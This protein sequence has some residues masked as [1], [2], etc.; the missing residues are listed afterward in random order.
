[1]FDIQKQMD[2]VL[3]DQI[4]QKTGWDQSSGAFVVN[5]FSDLQN[6]LEYFQW[7]H[8]AHTHT[9]NQ[10]TQYI[11]SYFLPQMSCSGDLFLSSVHFSTFQYISVHFST[12]LEDIVIQYWDPHWLTEGPLHLILLH[13][14]SVQLFKQGKKQKFEP[15]CTKIEF[16]SMWGS[17]HFRILF[18]WFHL[19]TLTL[20]FCKIN[21]SLKLIKP[22]RL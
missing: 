9:S 11:L 20:N 8:R 17:F 5:Q 3:W 12:F 1:M 13:K 21:I 10:Q 14:N 6:I 2:R 22:S 4:L 15:N 7:Q 19:T 18:Q 16:K